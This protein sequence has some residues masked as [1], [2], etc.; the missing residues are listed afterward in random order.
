MVKPDPQQLWQSAVAWTSSWA[1][2]ATEAVRRWLRAGGSRVLGAAAVV[3][4][5]LWV[6]PLGVG[7]A[8]DADGANGLN[9]SQAGASAN[10]RDWVRLALR[11]PLGYA[12]PEQEEQVIEEEYY[13][14]ETIP[15]VVL[16]GLSY[17]GGG[18]S[19]GFFRING[20]GTEILGVD[21]E[22]QGVRVVRL[23]KDHAVVERDG[24][25]LEL[26]QISGSQD[27]GGEL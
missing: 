13:E 26:R 21:E 27:D 5:L 7:S 14:E 15:E 20:G 19:V 12:E 18:R 9:G 24:E 10:D 22:S 4:L 17:R 25:R 16:V 1:L 23:T 6:W 3:M 2:P 11:R 8:G